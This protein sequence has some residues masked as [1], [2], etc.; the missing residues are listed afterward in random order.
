MRQK[1]I[2][3]GTAALVALLAGTAAFAD[4]TVDQVWQNWKARMEDGGSPVTVGSRQRTGDLLVLKDVTNT[5]TGNGTT[6]SA[7]IKQITLKQNGDGT[8]AMT[9]SPQLHVT[10]NFA[11]KGKPRVQMKVLITQT[12]PKITVSGNPGDMTYDFDVPKV[13]AKVVSLKQGDRT[14]D[15]GMSMVFLGSKS[16]YEVKTLGDPG[17]MTTSATGTMQELRLSVDATKPEPVAGDEAGSTAGK[18]AGG[19]IKVQANAK[20]L[21]MSF[22]THVAGKMQPGQFAQAVKSGAKFDVALGYKSANA[23]YSFEDQGKKSNGSA[24]AENGKLDFRLD[25]ALLHVGMSGDQSQLKMSLPQG[26][27]P[28]LSLDFAHTLFDMT[29]PLAQEAKPQDYALKL[30]LDGMSVNDAVWNLID[31]AKTLP[32]DPW[33]LA[34]DLA[35]K[36]TVLDNLLNLANAKEAP[37]TPPA[38]LDTLDIK[39][40][41]LAGAGADLSGTGALSFDNAARGPMPSGVI[42]LKLKDGMKLIDNL[43]KMGLLPQDEATGAKMMLGIFAKPGDTPDTLVSKIEMT[44]D[45]H[46][47]ANGQRLK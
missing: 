9:L 20:D 23:T 47:L 15:F 27:V 28:E 44:A 10:L 2:L 7:T 4:V 13:T 33:T 6:S 11:E 19:A 1:S 32:H 26:P 5:A 41:H 35:G 14:V 3:A 43:V 42:D 25:N 45:G 12:D 36:M 29:L 17:A 31:H 38:K 22:R 21:T 24:K 46:V 34:V 30:D 16:H 8:V 18:D 39:S 40:L 37:K